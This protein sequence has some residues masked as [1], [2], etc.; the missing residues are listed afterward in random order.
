M[1]AAR[2]VAEQAR[3]DEARPDRRRGKKAAEQISTAT[4]ATIASGRAATA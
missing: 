3:A 4:H 2:S 1:V